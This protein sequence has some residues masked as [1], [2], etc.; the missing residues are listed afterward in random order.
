M[1]FFGSRRPLRQARVFRPTPKTW[2]KLTASLQDYH[3]LSLLLIAVLAVAAMSVAIQSWRTRLP[4]RHGHV[5]IDGIQSRVDFQIKDVRATDRAQNLAAEQSRLV[6]RQN[7]DFWRDFQSRF[8]DELTEIANADRLSD[9]PDEIVEA[10]KLDLEIPGDAEEGFEPATRFDRVK[11]ALADDGMEISE[12]LD[13]ME[14]EFNG[15]INKVRPVGLVSLKELK[16]FGFSDE[17]L[18]P[19]RGIEIVSPTGQ[20][21]SMNL[22]VEVSLESQM[23]ETGQLG[24]AWTSLVNLQQIRPTVESWIQSQLS[25]QLI[26]DEA[27]TTDRRQTAISEVETIFDLYPAGRILVSPGTLLSDEHLEILSAEHAAHEAQ[28]SWQQIVGR[29]IGA[30]ILLTIM[31]AFLSTYLGKAETALLQE[32]AR[33]TTYLLICV[34]A[35]MLSGWLSRDP[36]R[37]EVLP[38]LTAVIILAIVQNQTLALLTSLCLC[39]LVSITT[40]GTV[41]HFVTLLAVCVMA[42]LPLNQVSS[43]STLIKIGFAAAGIAFVISLSVSLVNSHAFA[44]GWRDP[45]V[46]KIACK[47][48]GWSLVCCYLVAG[49]LPAVEKVFGIVTDISLLE[50]SDVSHPLLQE[51]AQRAPG[52]YNHS[53]TM[54]SIGEAAADS[55]GAN[56]LLLRVGAYF[57]DIG[58]GLKPE[59]FIEN[60]ASGAENPHDKLAPAMS[61]L[62]IIGHVK[63]GVELAEQHNLPRRLVDFIEQHHG[64]TLVEYFFR[65]ATNRADEDHRTDA[66]ESTFRYPGPKP[67]TK[68]AGVMMLADAV[69]SASRTLSEPTPKRIRSLIDQICLKRITDGQFD[70]SGLTMTDL[71]TI[72]DSLVKSLLAV[73]H[74]RV[75]YPDQKTA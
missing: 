8:K 13:Q 36:W 20:P 56:G 24:G 33:L 67:Q 4:W 48:A 73:H 69:E 18:R 63:D 3:V 42:V 29:V 55:I 14:K 39:L 16:Q 62:I 72:K 10:F 65:E 5:A 28:L 19:Q 57:H 30:G 46:L 25:G 34:L 22:L 6:F 43:R 37:A 49:S 74:G 27:L 68:E 60:M 38:L 17:D 59:Y 12:R 7:D 23:L 70:Q 31:V 58:K 40:V 44:I 1:S 2:D 66:D 54:A 75:K 71:T 45:A 35:V 11:M 52:T 21:V 9:V 47:F 53:I 15:W 32:P 64:T 51:L 50:L 41:G 61:A 26:A